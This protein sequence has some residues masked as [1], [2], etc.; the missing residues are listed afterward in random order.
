MLC[1]GMW[2]ACHTGTSA[3]LASI[4]IFTSSHLDDG[5]QGRSIEHERPTSPARPPS[6]PAQSSDATIG[7][8]KGLEARQDK[9]RTELHSVAT[10]ATL[11]EAKTATLAAE[12]ARLQRR[13]HGPSSSPLRAGCKAEFRLY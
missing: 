4:Y 13:V 7:T 2:L 6:H 1:S 3:A 9:Q 10:T 11:A 5:R 8:I 12:V